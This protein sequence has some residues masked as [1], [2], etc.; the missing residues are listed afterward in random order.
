MWVAVYRE[1]CESNSDR[2]MEVGGRRNPL[3]AVT[4]LILTRITFDRVARWDP[5]AEVANVR[6]LRLR[7]WVHGK[8]R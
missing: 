4:A 3:I 5:A 7:P 2:H 6:G 8:D 1:F